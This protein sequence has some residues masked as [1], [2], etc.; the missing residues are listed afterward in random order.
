MAAPQEPFR[1]PGNRA[2]RP[3]DAATLII[4]RRRKGAIEVLLGKRHA[5]HRFLP[6]RYVFPGGRV[7]RTDS[8]VRAA[9]PPSAGNEDQTA[10]RVA[11]YRY[12]DEAP[13]PTVMVID[14]ALP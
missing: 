8:R 3:K 13:G 10:A 11:Y 9:T 2:V 1:K 4:Y 12:I 7:D 6:S 14:P 5:S